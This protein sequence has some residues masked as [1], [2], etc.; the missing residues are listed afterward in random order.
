MQI[1]R[2][3]RLMRAVAG[4]GAMALLSLGL[5]S[6]MLAGTGTAHAAGNAF[7]RVVHAAP[8]AP[9]VDVYVDGTKLLSSFTFGTVTGYV[10]LAAG[11]HEIA[12]TPTG[13][14]INDAVIKQKVTVSADVTYTV[15][16]IGDS[17]TAP[18]LAAFVD[19]NAVAS[20]KAKVR[21]YHLSSDA[22]P[23]SVATGGQTVIPDLEFKAASA[24]LTVAPGSYTFDVTLKNSNK[25]VSQ[26]A[27]LEANKVTSVFAVGLASGSGD[28]ALKFVAAAVASTPTGL[29]STGFAPTS[30]ATSVELPAAAL[31][32]I[33]AGLVVIGG[34]GLALARRRTR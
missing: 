34:A 5:L 29:P 17:S 11:A 12:V 2:W 22:G 7:V 33:A 10:P 9:D 18:A 15:A 6:V 8:A 4:C 23:V 20:G 25:T 32:T 16:A 27:T 19:D 14:S 24:Y 13:K 28:T 31:Y 26:P 21:V 3:T 1:T 30:A